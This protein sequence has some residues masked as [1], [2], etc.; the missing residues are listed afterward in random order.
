MRKIG[1]VLALAALSVGMIIFASF[2]VSY[3]GPANS[4][5]KDEAQSAPSQPNIVFILADDMRKDDLQYMPKTRSLLKAN[6]MSFTNDFVSVPVCCPSR[7]TI[8]RG[9][10]AHNTGVL[11][12]GSGPNGGWQGY[13]SHGNE[14][15]NV[16]TRLQ[17]AGYRTGLI[18]K[19]LNGYDG[20]T[21]P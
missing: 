8:M 10:Y 2:F 18:G 4:V 5:R 13:Q 21:V 14:Q 16:A 20:S 12:N 17:G 3:I 7:A 19:Y 15:D 6:G 1:V 9:Q 11:E